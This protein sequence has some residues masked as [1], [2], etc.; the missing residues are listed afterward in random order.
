MIALAIVLSCGWH[1]ALRH[2]LGRSA[3]R[4]AVASGQR[5]Y[6]RRRDRRPVDRQNRRLALA[7]PA[8]RRVAPAAS[9]SADV[10][11]IALDVDFSTPS[12]A[13]S[14]QQLRRSAGE[15]RRIGGA[16]VLPAAPHRPDDPSHQSSACS[17]SP[18]IRGRRSSMSKSGRTA[19]FAAIRSARSST[20]NSC[21]RWARCWQDNTP[22][23][24]RRS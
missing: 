9:E 16:A 5:R 3:V 21:P 13:A 23:S 2:A 17:N 11:D 18:N 7:A 1:G 10:Q 19:W 20:A 4:L 22:K 8:P 14:D 12:D 15:R 24:A 6:R